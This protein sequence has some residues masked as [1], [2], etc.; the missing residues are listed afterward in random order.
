MFLLIGIFVNDAFSQKK[1][2]GIQDFK[3]PLGE[4]FEAG[5]TKLHIDDEKQLDALPGEGVFINGKS[6]R[7]VHFVTADQHGDLKLQLEFMVSKGSNSGVYLQGRY[8]VQILDSWGRAKIGS[9]D[10]GGIYQRW[11][12]NRTENKGYDGVPPRVNASKPPGEWQSL[13]INFKAPRFNAKGKKKKNARFKKVVL[14]GIVVHKNVEATG[15]TRSSL[16]DLEEP[17][18][19]LMLQGD[20]GPVAYRNIKIK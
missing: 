7:T 19:S 5:D 14:T 16:D 9:G 4:W 11:D 8:E 12:K 1:L 20:H 2:L 15:P 17:L 10:C 18:G 13:S 3:E 6:G